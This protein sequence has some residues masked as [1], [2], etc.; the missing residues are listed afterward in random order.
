MILLLLDA[1][2]Y[3]TKLEFESFIIILGWKNSRLGTKT[4]S[5]QS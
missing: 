5:S 4:I 3:V 1:E 2:W